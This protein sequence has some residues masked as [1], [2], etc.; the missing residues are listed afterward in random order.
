VT[1]VGCSLRTFPWICLPL[2]LPLVVSGCALPP[3]VIIASYA[4]DGVSYVATG[5]S[6]TDHGL[7][8]VAGHDCALLRPILRQKSIC[9]TAETA[10]AKDVRVEN[11]KNS[12]PRPG[13]ALAA[14]EPIAPR[15]ARAPPRAAERGYV[16]VGSFLSPDNAARAKAR[17]AGLNVAIVPVEVQGKQFH[18][19]VVGPL[20]GREAAALKA[21]LA[22]G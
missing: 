21:R 1:G 16:T 22:A 2:C 11:G 15:P 8:A 7:S 10:R 12:V 20:S 18:R 17:Y 5:K 3:A 4:A 13:S 19:V 14:A 9:D 6:V